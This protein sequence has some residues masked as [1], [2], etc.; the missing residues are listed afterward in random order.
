MYSRAVLKPYIFMKYYMLSKNLLFKS[1]KIQ[2]KYMNVKV[3]QHLSNVS[4]ITRCSYTHLCFT[5]II[6]KYW[7]DLA[8]EIFQIENVQSPKV[9]FEETSNQFEILSELNICTS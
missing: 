9:L 5:Q 7:E 8:K 2:S 6:I 1:N 3:F 4:W